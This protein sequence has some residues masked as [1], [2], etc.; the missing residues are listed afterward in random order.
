[1]PNFLTIDAVNYEVLTSN[2]SEEAPATGGITVEWA[3]DS[4][5]QITIAPERR[6]RTFGLGLTSI[7]AYEALRALSLLS[8]RSIGGPAMGDGTK[9]RIFIVEGAEYVASGVDFLLQANITV[10]DATA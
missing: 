9:S 4:S 1:M 2:A 8:P 3:W 5:P 6:Q 7:A 10:I